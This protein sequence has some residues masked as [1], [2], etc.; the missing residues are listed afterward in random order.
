MLWSRG[1]SSVTTVRGHRGSVHRWSVRWLGRRTDHDERGPVFELRPIW[2][3]Q[4]QEIGRLHLRGAAI[5]IPSD[6]RPLCNSE[7]L[8]GRPSIN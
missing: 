5:G 1:D 3:H 2:S 8:I 7:G 6:R 4:L